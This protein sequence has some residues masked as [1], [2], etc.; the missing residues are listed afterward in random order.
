MTMAE[1]YKPFT[2]MHVTVFS[3]TSGNYVTAA[4]WPPLL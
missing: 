4:G 1:F 3:G 2:I